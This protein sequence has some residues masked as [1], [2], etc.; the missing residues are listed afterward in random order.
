MPKFRKATTAE[1]TAIAEK[2]VKA[3]EEAGLLHRDAAQQLGISP[4]VLCAVEQGQR[5]ID[6]AELLV[7]ARL[8]GKR[9]S[10]FEPKG[11]DPGDTAKERG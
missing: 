4:S 10:W 11:R 5:R 2:L 3:R 9:L 8:Y 6:V 1:R 7:L